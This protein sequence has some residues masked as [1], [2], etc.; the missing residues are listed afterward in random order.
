LANSIMFSGGEV[1]AKPLI[2]NESLPMHMLK[3]IT[4]GIKNRMSLL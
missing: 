3:S 2:I 4:R 1:Y